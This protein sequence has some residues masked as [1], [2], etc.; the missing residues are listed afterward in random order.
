MATV[1]SLKWP[2]TKLPGG[3]HIPFGET[4]VTDN[5]ALRMIDNARAIPALEATGEIEVTY[6]P[7]PEPQN[8][9]ATVSIA[10]PE[11]AQAAADP[12]TAAAPAETETAAEPVAEATARKR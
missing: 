10:A 2:G 9:Q 12:V 8:I 7:D 3:Q 11:P 6:D 1:K 4:L 5:D